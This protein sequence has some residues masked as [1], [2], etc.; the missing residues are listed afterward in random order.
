VQVTGKAHDEKKDFPACH[1]SSVAWGQLKKITMIIYRHSMVL[2]PFCV[3]KQY[4]CGNYN[5]MAVKSHGKKHNNISPW[6]Q[7]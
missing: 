7:I 1:F 2:L 5:K 4:Y 3:I 6:W